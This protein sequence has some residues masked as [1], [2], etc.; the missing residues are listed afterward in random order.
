M[1]RKTPVRASKIGPKLTVKC[2][3][4]GKPLGNPLTH[5]CITRTDF[6]KRKREAEKP[7]PK[8]APSG[9]AHEYTACDDDDCHRFPC[10]VY[11][12]GFGDG[13]ERGFGDGYAS[14]YAS[15]FTEGM[16]S[17]PGPHSG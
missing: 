16:A 14:G 10:K 13:R 3:S 8:P 11:K 15:G 2:G 7:K 6:K 12:E 4:C 5:A 1:D 17:C 9:N